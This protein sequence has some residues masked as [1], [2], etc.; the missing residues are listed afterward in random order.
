MISIRLGQ[1]TAGTLLAS[2]SRFTECRL[3]AGGKRLAP[4]LSSRCC[5]HS[6]KL[7]LLHVVH[8]E[9]LLVI[10]LGLRVVVSGID[11]LLIGLQFNTLL[12]RLLG[13]I[14]APFTTSGSCRSSSIVLATTI[15][16]LLLIKVLCCESNDQLL[17]QTTIIRFLVDAVSLNAN[18]TAAALL[19]A[20]DR[21]ILL[22]ATVMSV[23]SRLLSAVHAVPDLHLVDLI[24]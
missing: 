14:H 3:L 13:I 2:F 10:L 19:G 8:L 5:P 17:F 12:I 24:L 21:T 4:W 7:G 9:R 1:R 18:A 11:Q 22:G 20:L 23:R 6:V 16:R 15:P